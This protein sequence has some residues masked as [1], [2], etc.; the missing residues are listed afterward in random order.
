MSIDKFFI[1]R[2][3]D[4][5]MDGIKIALCRPA[6]LLRAVCFLQFFSQ[7]L[8]QLA[9]AAFVF[10]FA[11]TESERG[12]EIYDHQSDHTAEADGKHK[13]LIFSHR[14]ALLMPRNH[15]QGRC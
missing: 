11:D 8:I 13:F 5:V 10:S 6:A 1:G 3:F 4:E 14:S 15:H 7:F 9:P 12:D 2:P